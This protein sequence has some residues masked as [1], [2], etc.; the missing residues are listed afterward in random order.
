[1]I[2]V[3]A[4][5]A[6]VIENPALRSDTGEV[7]L[8]DFGQVRLQHGDTEV[9]LA[10][11]PFPLYPGEVLRQEPTL[12]KIV[13]TNEALRLKALRDFVDEKN[14]KRMAGDEWHFEGP[15]WWF[16][17]RLHCFLYATF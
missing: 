16:F 2:T 11:E 12:M 7:L 3:S 4:R 5:H 17:P 6:C 14:V 1:M 10:Q 9:R 13:A 8:D 15:G